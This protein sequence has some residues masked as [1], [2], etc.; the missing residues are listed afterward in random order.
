M[1][2]LI[3]L[4]VCALMIAAC[5]DRTGST[6]KR[7]VDQQRVDTAIPA[8]RNVDEA[9]HTEA[10]THMNTI[11]RQMTAKAIAAPDKQAFYNSMNGK[12]DATK[13]SKLGMTE[14]ELTG[15]F[16]LPSDYTLSVS[17]SKLTI[18]AAQKGTR[19]RVEP[20]TFQLR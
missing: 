1:S 11:Y 15:K 7:F 6:N 9:V 10:M 14:A 8:I 4:C 19:G 13:L 5:E 12:L 20:Q 3:L 18:S 16:Y 2:K 17:G